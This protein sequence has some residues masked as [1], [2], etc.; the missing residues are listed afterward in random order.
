MKT[1][2]KRRPKAAPTT[3]G[4]LIGELMP[5]AI[6]DKTSYGNALDMIRRL[7][8]VPV[9]N[10]DQ[11]CYL[12]TLCVLVAAYEQKHRTVGRAKRKPLDAL[13]EFVAEHRMKVRELGAVMGVSESAASMIL[14]GDRSLTLDHVRKLAERFRVSASL[15]VG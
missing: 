2:T 5:T 11:T 10:A 4:A 7:A 9:L 14:N 8:V 15:F 1:A 12:D 3:F 13:R 6:H